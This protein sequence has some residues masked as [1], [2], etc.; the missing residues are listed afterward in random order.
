[1]QRYRVTNTNPRQPGAA[2]QPAIV[3]SSDGQIVGVDPGDTAD[4]ALLDWEL[5][6][7]AA[8]PGLTVVEL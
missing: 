6:A 4:L 5:A 7:A 2:R 3:L 1:M 8:E